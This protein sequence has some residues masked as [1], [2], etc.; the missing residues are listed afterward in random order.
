MPIVTPESV[1]VAHSVGLAVHVFDVDEESEM[2][3]LIDMV[4]KSGHLSSESLQ[5]SACE[6]FAY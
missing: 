5:A 6:I 1:A 2:V 4:A 3:Q